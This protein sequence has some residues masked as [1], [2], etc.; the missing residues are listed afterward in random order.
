[1]KAKI[2]I[3]FLLEF[4]TAGGREEVV[5]PPFVDI[6]ISLVNQP[7]ADTNPT[8]QRGRNVTNVESNP[9]RQRGVVAPIYDLADVSG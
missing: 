5:E 3:L 4:L 7:E 1:M 8:R 2:K 6:M 9:K